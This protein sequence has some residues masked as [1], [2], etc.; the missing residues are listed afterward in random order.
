MVNNKVPRS[1][2]IS[3]PPPVIGASIILQAT[4][5]AATHV[6]PLPVTYQFLPWQRPMCHPC[7]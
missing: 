2:A 3:E 1:S 5:F 6:P 4:T 7:Q